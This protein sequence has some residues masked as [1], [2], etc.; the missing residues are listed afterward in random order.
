MQRVPIVGKF[1]RC[2]P[3]DWKS[4]ALALVCAMPAA[5]LEPAAV[6]TDHMV[7]PRDVPVPVWGT[8]MPGAE[9]VVAFAGREARGSAGTDGRWRVTLDP[10]PASAAPR[11]LL[12]SS[13]LDPRPSTLSDLLVGDIWLASGQSNMDW[14][15][16]D[17]TGAKKA[18]EAADL[19]QIRLLNMEPEKAHS[20]QWE[21]CSPASAGGFSAVAFFF[22]RALQ[23]EI[24][25]PVG[26][27]ANA[28]GG[29]PMEAWMT[30]DG[31]RADARGRVVADDPR[32]SR[33]YSPWA[34]GRL[35]GQPFQPGRLYETGIAP[36][37]PLPIK[38][39]IWYQGETNAEHY[40]IDPDT[41]MDY[42]GALFASM[43]GSWRSAWGREFPFLCVQLP[44]MNRSTWPWFREMQE[45]A[46]GRIP[47]SAMAVIL[48]HGHPTDVHPRDK[49]PV[50]ER[51][52]L[53]ARARAYGQAVVAEGPR[54]RV[55]RTDPTDRTDR[56]DCSIEFATGAPLASLDG[57]PLRHFAIAGEDRRF[58]P[59]QAEIRG[60]EVVVSSPEVP[61]PVAVR[62]AWAPDPLLSGP[63]NFF[64][65]AG[66]PAAPFRTDRW[67]CDHLPIRVACIG[68]SITEGVGA[69]DKARTSYPVVLQELL[70]N[71]FEVRNFGRGGCTVLRSATNEWARGYALQP[72]HRAALAFKPDIVVC[73]LGINDV[74]D[75]AW[76][77]FGPDLDASFRETFAGDYLQIID[78]Y[79]KIEPPPKFLM[80]CPAAPL[81][82]GQRYFGSPRLQVIRDALR[83]VADRSGAEAVDMEAAFRG[84][85]EHARFFPD[86]LHPDDRG[87]RKIAEAVR[88]AIVAMGP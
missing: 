41:L 26:I 15:L 14:P 7:L 31:L 57:Q 80:W 51:L 63:L 87:H 20:G 11:E 50:G 35:P 22:A 3:N 72:Q 61:R 77:R 81:F 25:V 74:S 76:E 10:M 43:V 2:F 40:D 73:N 88:Q 33:L 78:E 68:D 75:F 84:E 49:R 18:M 6:F 44:R 4:A 79:R 29:S 56:A 70:G 23:P 45:D 36:L 27:I 60:T 66:L 13:S 62:Y 5:A 48:E 28:V 37:V 39:V 52:A 9:V 53:L 16:K 12:I 69:S 24:G 55:Q 58:V 59:A 83:D 34:L 30:K 19:P 8:A 71:S 67:L 46:L 32:R 82:K 17:A 1:R 38:G 21:R 42:N 65:A 54:R 47:G 85:K 86:G 64:N